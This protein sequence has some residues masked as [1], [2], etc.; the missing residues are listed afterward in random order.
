MS[1]LA[2][3]VLLFWSMVGALQLMLARVSI[4]MFNRCAH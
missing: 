1:L 2:V 4:L 3:M